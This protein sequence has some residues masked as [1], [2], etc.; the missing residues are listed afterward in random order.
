VS[1]LLRRLAQTAR[2]MVGQPDYDAYRRHLAD[3]HPERPVMTRA[4]FFR[5]REAAR[6]RGGN[7]RCC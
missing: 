7:G 3:H 4:Q 6:Y 2:L 5:D 1:G